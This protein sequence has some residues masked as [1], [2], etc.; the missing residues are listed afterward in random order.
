MSSDRSRSLIF[1]RH[2]LPSHYIARDVCLPS[3]NIIYICQST[4][5]L[6]IM[7]VFPFFTAIKTTG[8]WAL[9]SYNSFVPP[10]YNL[11]MIMNKCMNQSQA[12]FYYSSLIQVVTNNACYTGAACVALLGANVFCILKSTLTL[13][14]TPP[15]VLFTSE[16]HLTKTQYCY[17][18]GFQPLQTLHKWISRCWSFWPLPLWAAQ[19]SW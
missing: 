16:L 1:L 9:E 5:W 4:S 15:D 8:G 7:L 13:H 17:N 12:L 2:F 19:L 3:S 18:K 6:L 14:Y 11:Y 10:E